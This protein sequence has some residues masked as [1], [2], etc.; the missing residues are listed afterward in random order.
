M[1]DVSAFLRAIHDRPDDDGPRLVYADWLDEQGDPRG[2]FIRLQC[3]LAQLGED[4]PRRPGLE[5]READLRR[6]H[7]RGWRAELPARPGITWGSYERGFVWSVVAETP[8]AFLEHATA[9]LAAA[10]VQRL[11]VFRTR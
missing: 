6:A 8:L 4:D 2:E 1:S 3:D 11:R 10:P 7:D 9:V 5:W